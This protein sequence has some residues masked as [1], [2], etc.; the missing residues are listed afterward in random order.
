M[1]QRVCGTGME[2][3]VQAADTI[4]LGK[5]DLALVAGTEST[6]RN[7]IAAYTHRGGFR[8]GRIQGLL[9]GS[10]ARHLPEP[11]HGSH[12]RGPG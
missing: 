3:I 2:A 12:C 1:V 9:V 7:P 5:A 8:P 11:N 4:K 6:L 10:A